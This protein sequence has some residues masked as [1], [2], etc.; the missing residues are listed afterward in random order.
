MSN[1]NLICPYCRSILEPRQK[2]YYCKSCLRK[3]LVYTVDGL[4]IIDFSSLDTQACMCNRDGITRCRIELEKQLPPKLPNRK[5]E[6]GIQLTS[7][8]QLI[9]SEIS[10]GNKILDLG[11]GEGRNAFLLT[12]E[13]DAYGLDISPKRVLLNEENS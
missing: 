10:Q 3:Y 13:N 5:R 1:L 9:K 11:C 6:K 12:E 4:N 8:E 7:R 2:S